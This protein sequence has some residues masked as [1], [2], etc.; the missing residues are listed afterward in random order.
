MLKKH[1]R[2]ERKD[3]ERRQSVNGSQMV[4]LCCSEAGSFCGAAVSVPIGRLVLN[5]TASCSAWNFYVFVCDEAI[6][7]LCGRLCSV[8]HTGSL[9]HHTQTHTHTHKNL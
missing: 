6:A 8:L 7:S 4:G 3:L 9:C 5:V 2:R 1:Q